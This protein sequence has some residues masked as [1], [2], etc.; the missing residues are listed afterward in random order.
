MQRQKN[1]ISSTCEHCTCRMDN[2]FNKLN[3]DEIRLIS[4]H[5]ICKH[6]QKGDTIFREGMRSV[7]LYCISYGKVKIFKTGD[8]GRDQI[9]RLAGTGDI[10]GYRALI[11][12][13]PYFASAV[14]LEDSAVCLVPL[15]DFKT[16]VEQNQSFTKGLLQMLSHDLREA[17]NRMLRMAQKSVRERLAAT[18]L[19]LIDTYGTSGP[20]NTLK[21]EL[22]REEMASLV[23][24]ATETVIRLISDF[25]TEGLI[26]TNGKKINIHNEK[27]LRAIAE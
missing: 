13:E 7:G 15:A 4:S 10:I 22:S 27:A 16:F 3:P 19:L 25:K 17:E 2:V 8:E 6:F 12:D 24:T 20:D 21:I 1:Q 23:G 5:K 26:V 18:L 11:S 9:V 14:A